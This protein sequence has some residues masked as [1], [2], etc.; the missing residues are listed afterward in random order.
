MWTFEYFIET[1]ASA[2]N[3]WK[4]MTDVE[5]WNK[6]ID[7]V[8]YSSLD[9]NFENGT[10]GTTKGVS[11]PKSTFC[12]KNVVVNKSFINQ[13]K[14]PLCTADGVHEIINEDNGLKIKLG[15]NMYG[16]LTFIFKRILAKEANKSIPI[17]A[18]KTG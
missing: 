1:T 3:V 11:G 12:L 4:I 9:G 7:S 17:S 18:K 10:T 14:M 6:W 8:E 15:I 13:T 2:E 5:N 16:P